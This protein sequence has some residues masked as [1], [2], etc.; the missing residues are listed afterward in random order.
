MKKEINS[1]VTELAKVYGFELIRSKKHL[2]FK[3]ESGIRLVTGKS[4]SDNRALKNVESTIKK[5]LSNYD[6]SNHQC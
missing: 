2:I 4:I 5:L 3:H 1:R 6:K